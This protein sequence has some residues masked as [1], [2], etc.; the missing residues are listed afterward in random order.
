MPSSKLLYGFS[1]EALAF[2]MVDSQALRWFCRIGIADEGFQKS[3]LKSNIKR[4]S[5]IAWER[6]NRD[7]LGYANDQGIEKGRRVRTD[8]TCVE[9]NI[10]PPHDSTLLWDAVRVLTR[11]INRVKDD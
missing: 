4:I 7:I 11:L 2:H 3:G 9:S 5:D 6:I 1:Y 8:C 10:H